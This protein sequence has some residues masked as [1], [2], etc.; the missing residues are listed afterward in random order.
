MLQ[1]CFQ[2]FIFPSCDG[3]TKLQ[4]HMKLNLKHTPFS[5]FIY[6]FIFIFYGRFSGC[7][8][9]L[10]LSLIAFLGS[11]KRTWMEEKRARA[12]FYFLN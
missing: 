6:L 11:F 8:R 5:R 7:A 4:N 1:Q 3:F 12:V 9:A 2:L 10:L